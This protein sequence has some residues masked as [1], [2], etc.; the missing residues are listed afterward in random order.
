MDIAT[1][2]IAVRLHAMLSLVGFFSLNTVCHAQL[3]NLPGVESFEKKQV[4]KQYDRSKNSQLS[5]SE[6]HHRFGTSALEWKWNGAESSFGTS[7]FKILDRDPKMLVYEDIFPSSPTLVFSVYKKEPQEGTVKIS[8]QKNGEDR[9]W[10]NIS[11]QFKGW[12][13]VRV[14]FYEM[15]GRPPEKN[16]AD[17]KSVV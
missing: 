14:P 13:T 12:R 17:R 3:T 8:Y 5:V 15:Q 4:L 1:L 10:F 9:A 16:C 6:T 2:K 11:L 7:K